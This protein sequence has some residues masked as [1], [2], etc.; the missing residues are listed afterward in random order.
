MP[1]VPTIRDA[2]AGHLRATGIALGI[3]GLVVLAGWYSHSPLLT[4]FVPSASPLVAAAALEFLV[5]GLG[6]VAAAQQWNYVVLACGLLVVG[7]SVAS[8]TGAFQAHALR[9]SDFFWQST[10]GPTR[11]GVYR[12][13]PNAATAFFLVGFSL[14]IRSLRSPWRGFMPILGGVVLAFGVLPLLTYLSWVLVAHGEGAYDGVAIPTSVGLLLCAASMLRRTL[15]PGEEPSSVPVL[16]AALAMLASI[17]IVSVE[18]NAE[19]ISANRWVTHT[20]QVRSDIDSLVSEVARMESSARAYA[21]TGTPSFLSR[22]EYHRS[23][24]IAQLKDVRLLVIDDDRQVTRADRLRA[25]ADEKFSQSDTFLRLRREKGA[26]AAAKY[27]AELPATVTSALV[28]EADLMKADETKLLVERTKSRDLAERSAHM[29]EILG[30]LLSV[31]LLGVAVANA[32]RAGIARRRAE[33]DLRSANELLDRRVKE[34]TARLEAEIAEHEAAERAL[35]ESEV[36]LRFVADAMPQL[37]WTN[38][39]DG[40]FESLNRRWGDYLGLD[41]ASVVAAIPAAIH[42]EDYPSY[43]AE[44]KSMIDQKRSGAGEFR[45][46]RSDGIY[47]WHLW[48]AQPQPDATGKRVLRWIG[49][50]TDI[51]DQKEINQTLERLVGERTAAMRE[52][53]ERFRT[54]FDF[55]AIGMA[56]LGIDGHWLRVNKALCSIVGYSP[57]ELVQRTAED[58]THE[59]DRGLDTAQIDELVRRTRQSFQVEKRYVHKGGGTVWVHI[60]A[61]LVCD[62]A[63]RPVYIV[64]QIEDITTRKQLEESL[65]KARDQALEASRLKSEFLANMSHEIRTPMNGVVGMIGLLLDTPLTAEQR[66]HAN[67][68]RMSAESLLTVI[69]DILDFSKIEAGQLNIESIPFTLTEPV[70][71]CLG[72]LA[73]KAQSKGVELAYLIEETVPT[74]VIG[75]GMRLQQVLLNLASNAIK[76]TSKGEV[77]VKV[78]RV[79]EGPD[80]VKLRFSVRDTG[81]GIPLDAQ[82]KLFQPFVQAD[83]STTRK[84]GGTGLGLAICRQLV[85]L[86]NGTIGLESEVGKGS[87]FWFELTLPVQQ[88]LPKTVTFKQGL[89]G[90]RALVVDDNLTN[91]EILSQQLSAWLVE[92]EGVPDGHTAMKR[93]RSSE[94]PFDFAVLD[95][96][97]PGMSG[98][99]LA[100]LI[101]ADPAYASLKIVILTSMGH[102]LSRGQMDAAG[103]AV[104]LVKP[105]RQAQLHEALLGMTGKAE[106]PEP[107]RQARQ[108]GPKQQAEIKLRILIAEDNPVNQHVARLQLERF[109]YWPDVVSNG[110]EAVAA[111]K[112]TA[113]DVVLMDCQMPDMD[114]FEATRSIRAWEAQMKADGKAAHPLHIIAMTANAMVGDR[115]ECIAAGMDDYVTKPV[116]PADLAAALARSAP[117]SRTQS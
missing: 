22:Y 92:A 83:G 36:T 76:F 3:L 55:A 80:G 21:L 33:A 115:E 40:T 23:E 8:L 73:E 9:L 51:H 1:T 64:A 44:W 77:V 94:K 90:K 68:V 26:E 97:M 38:R 32:R 5:I 104:C 37:T 7:T 42:A 39:A 96:Q 45:L 84:F 105:A 108:P 117:A 27:L 102:L 78:Q 29:I 57:D 106:E 103:V 34:R 14:V 70:E 16:V 48:R 10:A 20:Y 30:G 56:L 63:Q 112:A 17:A 109:G 67:T 71:N 72:F 19:V 41:A 111:V 4:S 28:N 91:R 101:R 95:M 85:T 116:R 35:R 74:Q 13:E 43:S 18:S 100:N 60:T 89:A 87:T 54:A 99:E 113:Y 79:S 75:D 98:L 69:N 52:S 53:E 61:S 66:S 81:L 93:L 62:A 47:R 24:V 107:P 58:I 59:D 25:L 31:A 11:A 110:L 86:M 6:L 15:A 82:A 46:R 50:A 12:L 49:S 2:S 114:G 65:A 88:A